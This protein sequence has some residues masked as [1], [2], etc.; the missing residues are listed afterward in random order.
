MLPIVTLQPVRPRPLA[1][2][3]RKVTSAGIGAIWRPA[4]DMVWEF[5]RRQPALRTDGHNIFLYRHPEQPGSPFVCDFGVEVT[6]TFPPEGDV[7]ATATPGGEAAVTIHRGAYQR[8]GE[9]HQ[10]VERWIEANGRASAGL[11]WEIYG[12]PTPDPA[13]TET[14]VLYL[15]K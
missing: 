6:Q 11:S 4:L 14:T 7:F 12:D 10:A 9:A 13:D 2:V 1:A 3:R 5:I 8:L 15:L